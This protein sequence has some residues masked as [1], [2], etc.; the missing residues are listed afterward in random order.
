MKVESRLKI[1]SS[2]LKTRTSSHT[3]LRLIRVASDV[4]P[5]PA[6]LTTHDLLIFSPSSILNLSSI[7]PSIRFHRQIHK[8]ARRPSPITI[9][10]HNQPHPRPHPHHFATFSSP[11]SFLK[12]N[13]MA[14]LGR[15][16][17]YRKHLTDAVLND[18]PEPKEHGRIAKVVATRGGNQFDILLSTTV[19]KVRS[20]QLALFLPTKFHKLVWVKREATMPLSKQEEKHMSGS[21]GQ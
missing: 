20:P 15:R 21:K 2:F 1:H 6:L 10:N 11:N 14:G 5:L 16:T 18:L 17:H 4:H 12:H 9:S 13:V 3:G 7:Y 19:E 8:L